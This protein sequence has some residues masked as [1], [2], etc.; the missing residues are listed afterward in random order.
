[1]CM[2]IW[3]Y[4]STSPRNLHLSNKFWRNYC[5]SDRV[6]G[7][8]AFKT[9][10][11]KITKTKQW[12]LLSIAYDRSSHWRSKIFKRSKRS[13]YWD[14][15]SW[16]VL[17]SPENN[18]GSWR[19]GKQTENSKVFSTTSWNIAREDIK[20]CWQRSVVVPVTDNLIVQ[21]FERLS[22]LSR[23]SIFIL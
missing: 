6:Y 19:E 1:M 3:K 9:T 22:D 21:L 2:G 16:L 10:C 12:H 14:W 8:G 17:Y 11:Y 7:F 18:Y 4:Q 15:I 23:I 13:K 20:W 5:A